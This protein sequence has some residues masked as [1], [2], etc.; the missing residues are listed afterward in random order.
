MP[1][2][3]FM[4]VFAIG[5]INWLSRQIHALHP[6]GRTPQRFCDE[7]LTNAF[8]SNATQ[9][10]CNCDHHHGLVFSY[11][12]AEGEDLWQVTVGAVVGHR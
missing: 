9:D 8:V 5:L 6:D 11:G 12:S 7:L 2:G 10:D 1:Q 3:R 4:A